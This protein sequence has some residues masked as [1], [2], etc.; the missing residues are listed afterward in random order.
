MTRRG[1]GSGRGNGRGR[2]RERDFGRE[3]SSRD[4]QA[5][6]I[7]REFVN[8]DCTR[9]NCRFSHDTNAAN[10]GTQ[11][12]VRA[13]ETEEQQHARLQYNG[14][15]KF[16][17]RAYSPTD[18]YTMQRVWEGALEILQED[19][20]DWKQ[21]L[22]RDLDN[23]EE[24]CNGR[25][26]I[27]A[28]VLKRATSSN[29]TA[30]VETV[31]DFLVVITHS[32]LLDCLAVDEYVTGIYNFIAGGGD[33]SRAIEFFLHVCEI[34]VSART[35]E[36]V[37]VSRNA[38]EKAIIRLT[39]ALYEL[40]YRNR[41]ARFNDDLT[42][43]LTALDSAAE[44]IPASQPSVTTTIVKKC[45]AD[46]QAM[47]NR[48]K[49]LVSDNDLDREEAP[50]AFAASVYPRDLAV[51]AN[52][53]DND[54][55]DI[56]DVTIFPTQG[57]LVSDA[58]EILP[59]TD[60]D[61]PHYLTEKIARHIDTNFRL[62]RH[63]VFG[64]LK[65][66]LSGLLHAAKDDPNAL[67]KAKAHL[68]DMR[69][70]YYPNTQISFVSFDTRRGLQ[71]K[72]SFAQPSGVRG[73][74]AGERR[75]WWEESRR[76]EEGSLLSYIFIQGSVIQHLFFT[77]T[78]KS[79]NPGQ[80]YGLADRDFVATITAKLTTQDHGS[81]EILTS[82]SCSNAHGVLIEFPNI[83]PATFVPILKN[84]QDMQR[85][86]RLRFS[87]W[88]LPDRYDSPP[89]VKV[90]QD[91]PP[92]I[93]VRTPGFR[94]SLAAIMKKEARAID[95]T[96]SIEATASCS[97][98]ALVQEIATKTELDHGQCRALIA[99]LTREFAFIQGPPGT[100]KSY[101]GLQVMRLLLEIKKK[102][103]L[104]PIIVV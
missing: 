89:H 28:L 86:S 10:G 98:E 38:V 69:V 16:L 26:H 101:I 25:A 9:R 21:Q 34:L 46:V 91:I 49:G 4:G 66:A 74:P 52:R 68:G 83:L 33:G 7:C 58:K 94:F 92:P 65:K 95:S 67:M 2:N 11:R 59:S 39:T 19:D 85:L 70:H 3:R 87:Q 36:L 20:R 30:Y 12:K 73:R 93:Y 43:L 64:E 103:D 78:Q 79:T 60:P 44:I 42:K 35:D 13:E 97:D 51:P 100:G 62:Y 32:S 54:K 53:H 37:S 40:L 90:Y 71:A 1:G 41:R 72:I 88:L 8:G 27:K 47:I 102:A 57:E 75:F 6:G 84:L 104:G 48:A 50:R 17:G 18:S 14:W 81:L 5:A 99:A 63:D 23:D 29:I 31:T 61:Q 56:S 77:V 24:K 82:A 96:F 15:K 80:E 76:L 45:L 22:P 55:F